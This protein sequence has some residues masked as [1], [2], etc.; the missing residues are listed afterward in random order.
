MAFIKCFDAVEMVLDEASKQFAPLFRE[1]KE[2]KNI[3]KTYCDVIDTIA[4]DFHGE[5]FEVEVDDIKMSVTIKLECQDMIIR[6]A[7]HPFYELT[8][9][10]NAVSFSK[11]DGD[12]LCVG[13]VFPSIWE[14]AV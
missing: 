8:R 11:G 13:F 6:S 7:E 3:L 9:H 2:K 14:K 5:S 12:N 10:A 1:D 4:A